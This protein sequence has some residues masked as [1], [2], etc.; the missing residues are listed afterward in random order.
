[1]AVWAI[2]FP[3]DTREIAGSVE[4]PLYYAPAATNPNLRAQAGVFTTVSRL[5]EDHASIEEHMRRL[6]SG[7]AQAAF[8][9]FKVILPSTEARKL[10]R[11]LSY[12]GIDGASMFPGADGVVRAMR[13]RALWD[14]RDSVGDPHEVTRFFAAY[15]ATS[16][17]AA[18]LHHRLAHLYAVTFADERM[19]SLPRVR[20]K[21]NEALYGELTTGALWARFRDAYLGDL[22]DVVSWAINAKNFIARDHPW[23]TKHLTANPEGL[24]VLADQLDL[25]RAFLQSV[26]DQVRAKERAILRA[27]V[28]PSVNLDDFEAEWG[29]LGEP[30]PEVVRIPKPEEAIVRAWHA[31]EDGLPRIYFENDAGEIWQLN[32]TG[33]SETRETSWRDDWVPIAE[34]QTHLPARIVSRP[35]PPEWRGPFDYDL[36]F[37]TGAHLRLEL[38]NTRAGE[39]GR[40]TWEV[41]EQ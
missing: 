13:E 34:I 37:S 12:E 22:D 27:R 25:A 18:S 11:L 40:L 35:D 19:A 21:R 7:P 31:V 29:S 32:E 10:L 5:G 2:Y 23:W 38:V 3:P 28:G 36:R 20:E 26:C 30:G 16:Y 8:P 41:V 4:V 9:M 17:V 1:M 33:L 6:R 24:T 15:G 14:D 39:P